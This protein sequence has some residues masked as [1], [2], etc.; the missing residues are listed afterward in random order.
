MTT[1]EFIEK[2]RKIHGDKYDYSKVE[3]KGCRNKVCI[4][5]PIHGEFWQTPA[6]HLAKKECKKCA[7]IES[8]KKRKTTKEEF[9]EKAKQKHGNK[10]DYS[11]VEYVNRNTKVCIICPEHGE[12]WQSPHNHLLYGCD[13]CA[14]VIR[15]NNKRATKE[16]F[17]EK[18]K[19]KHGNKYDYSKVEYVNSNTKVCIICPEHGEFWQTP[20]S[21]LQYGCKQCAD[22]QKNAGKRWTNDFFIEQ[23]K[24]HHGNT[25]G[26]AGI[27]YVNSRTPVVVNCKKH[28][29][30]KDLPMHF[31][32]YGCMECYKD[33][34]KEEK[35]AKIQEQIAEKKIKS[36][37][38]EQKAKDKT[39]Y[40]L[41]EF[42]KIHGDKYDY[43]KVGTIKNKTDKICIICPEH[44]EFWQRVSNHTKGCGCS[45]C[46]REKA[47]QRYLS[48]TED[49][50][51]KAKNVHGD[52]YDYSKV[53][54]V[55]SKTKVCII[56]PKH[57]EFWQTP[58]MHVP[59][60]QGCPECGT[61]SS[62]A[63]NEI[64][65]F[66][67]TELGVKNAIKR[68][69]TIIPPKELD[70]YLPSQ[71]LAI[72][73]NGLRWHS[74]KFQKDKM[75]HINKTLDC[76]KK[77]V[78]LIQIF[79]DE[80]E[81][82]KE[83][84][85]H[86]IKHLLNCDCNL[87]KIFARKCFVKEISKNEC[88]DF[89]EEYHIQGKTVSSLRF[90]AFYN[91][92]LIGVMSFLKTE[93][94]GEYILNRFTTDYSY[95]ISGVGGKILHYFKEKYA[96]EK[97]ISFAD[98]RWTINEENNLY[99]KLGFTLDGILQPDYRY[100]LDSTSKIERIHKFNFRKR[101]L[102]K[103]YGFGLSMTESQMAEKLKAYKVWD[104]GLLRYVW[105]KT[106]PK[107]LK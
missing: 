70:I 39:E 33:K 34:L 9:I 105:R 83:I 48:N 93:K 78:G 55:D 51:Q 81:K 79:E 88:D 11:K 60:H 86:K 82:R 103:K 62:H 5:C 49:F 30:F 77:G 28:G 26:T 61:L 107:I 1:I 68:N 21:H 44:G 47:R 50:I 63:E 71:N 37:L 36:K 53:E 27:Q 12:F 16:E 95:K 40:Y 102:H 66:I 43:S 20:S 69:K 38:K 25:Y 18:A 29:R 106:T 54:Y 80:W 59:D 65:D 41:S 6:Q 104:C 31:L 56:C 19:Q 72:E 52:K 74:E 89:M 22:V 85:K 100:Y 75:Y 3:Y 10:Y 64:Y 45:K 32:K 92:K 94:N 87:P 91:D 46:A 15:A 76:Q 4:I 98:R 14:N 96:P 73:F 35:N 99:T 101:T 2:A 13:K 8:W 90:G 24:K 97:I 17:I 42:K 84:V 67:F 7:A 57:G 58:A 23:I